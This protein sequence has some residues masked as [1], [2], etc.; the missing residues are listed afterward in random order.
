VAPASSTARPASPSSSPIAWLASVPAPPPP[1]GCADA[2]SDALPAEPAAAGPSAAA[3]AGPAGSGDVSRGLTRQGNATPAAAIAAAALQARAPTGTVTCGGAATRTARDAAAATGAAPPSSGSSSQPP[4]G[5]ASGAS[6]ESRRAT[7]RTAAG[8]SKSA[9]AGW[10]AA[11]ASRRARRPARRG[12][13][14]GRALGAGGR[15]RHRASWRPGTPPARRAPRPVRPAPGA[16]AHARRSPPR[17]RT[18]IGW[19]LVKDRVA[20][21]PAGRVGRVEVEHFHI[22]AQ[23]GAQRR[24]QDALRL[25][26]RQQQP[27]RGH[28]GDRRSASRSCHC[29]D[30]VF[31]RAFG[32]RAPAFTRTHSLDRPGPPA[33]PAAP[34]RRWGGAR[35]SS[36]SCRSRTARPRPRGLLTPRCPR[37]AAR[38]PRRRRPARSARRRRPWAPAAW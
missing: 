31:G 4:G 10:V 5:A 6:M 1:R 30:R 3:E 22:G 26:G 27:E 21:G 20:G 25:G 32:C 14:E 36:R 23:R 7:R 35:R 29:R 16:P 18:R 19:E 33:A 12:A 37:P 15:R 11:K 2:P 9:T 13:R 17:P 8:A 34:A 38:P 24:R 28:S